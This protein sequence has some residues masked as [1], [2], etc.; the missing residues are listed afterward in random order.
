MDVRQ[1]DRQVA[2][3]RLRLVVSPKDPVPPAIEAASDVAA[4]RLLA[5]VAAIQ[6][7]EGEGGYTPQSD[8]RRGER[9]G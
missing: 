9:Y 4:Q 7:W 1:T 2:S 3:P 8:E 6:T 5:A